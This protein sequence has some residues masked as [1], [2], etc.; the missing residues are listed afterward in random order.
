MACF[1]NFTFIFILKRVESLFK[2]K[3]AACIHFTKGPSKHCLRYCVQLPGSS[4]ACLLPLCCPV[5][6]A[7][8]HV[9]LLLQGTSDTAEEEQWPLTRLVQ[10]Q[11]KHLGCMSETDTATAS[12]HGRPRLVCRLRRLAVT[13]P[14]PILL[15]NLFSV[16]K[17]NTEGERSCELHLVCKINSVT[18]S[19]KL[20]VVPVCNTATTPVLQKHKQL[21]VYRK[22]HLKHVVTAY[23]YVQFLLAVLNSSVLLHCS[24]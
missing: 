15:K 2:N 14:L 1:T 21:L 6:Q 11:G 10:P 3:S 16:L 24:S 8:P 22:R 18:I 4:P 9:L 23:K 7:Q 20:R 17:C 19:G 12:R 5:V 13:H